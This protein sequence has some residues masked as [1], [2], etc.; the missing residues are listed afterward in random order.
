V[1]NDLYRVIP[2]A[3]RPS[4]IDELTLDSAIDGI[5]E[6][7]KLRHDFHATAPVASHQRRLTPQAL[8]SGFAK[9]RTASPPSSKEI[10]DRYTAVKRAIRQRIFTLQNY[11]LMQFILSR[12]DLL[13]PDI[14]FRDGSP[15]LPALLRT[16]REHRPDILIVLLLNR[17]FSTGPV[18][19]GGTPVGLPGL[20][21]AFDGSYV[22]TQ[23]SHD[24]DDGGYRRA[25]HRK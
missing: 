25:G 21:T 16:L 18:L 2:D 17:P 1:S 20:G 4:A 12:L 13:L 9:A 3:L 22:L 23:V 24:L 11:E 15:P 19:H 6:A 7:F 14:R 5:R 8:E 10:A